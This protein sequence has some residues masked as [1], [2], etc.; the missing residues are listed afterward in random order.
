MRRRW[1]GADDLDEQRNESLLS[2]SWTLDSTA[3]G[4]RGGG[5]HD[6]QP[7]ERADLKFCSSILTG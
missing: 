2:L 6:K 1:R 3:G 5:G 4:E 7:Q